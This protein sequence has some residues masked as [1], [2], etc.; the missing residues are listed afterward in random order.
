MMLP[1]YTST[2]GRFRRAIAIIP[3][4]MVLS[5]P[6]SA[7]TPSSRRAKDCQLDRVGDHLAADQRRLHPLGPHGDAVGDRDGGE[8][9]GDAAG[10]ADPLLDLLAYLSQVCLAGRELF[11]VLATPISGLCPGPRR[12]GRRRGS[13]RA[14]APARPLGELAALCFKPP[15]RWC[16]RSVFPF[17]VRILVVRGSWFNVGRDGPVLAAHRCCRRLPRS[18]RIRPPT[19]RSRSDPCP[20]LLPQRS[21]SSSRPRRRGPTC[22]TL[23]A[24]RDQ[25]PRRSERK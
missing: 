18:G 6:T 10:G 13:K 21:P 15:F 12:T 1:P 20:S 7:T 22:D 16:S 4:G 2:D 14:R 11:Q 9:Q 25:Q 24:V 23:E 8:L 17:V 3:P 19:A 5:Q